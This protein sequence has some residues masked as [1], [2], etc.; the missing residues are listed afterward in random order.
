MLNHP[1]LGMSPRFSV[2]YRFGTKTA[3]PQVYAQDHLETAQKDLAAGRYVEALAHLDAAAQTN[4][5]LVS[6]VW[7]EKQ[8]RLTA[9]LA[10]TGWRKSDDYA[11]FLSAESEQEQLGRKALDAYLSGD[12]RA[13]SLWAHVALAGRP[14][15]EFFRGLLSHLSAL[16]GIPERGEDVLTRSS[17]A[18][19][20]ISRANSAF[21]YQRYDAASR[22]FEDVVL[23]EEN[24]SE[25]WVK[26][27]SCYFALGERER[28]RE[29]Y[30]RA[31]KLNAAEPTLLEFMREQGWS[32]P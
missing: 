20:K 13:A 9:L 27:G 11:R 32:T 18:Q 28:A 17:L 1:T 14:E 31:L 6:G 2:G 30:E 10:K 8:A 5:A 3:R 29:A 12:N 21:Y 25:A 19:E 16:S 24:N 22:E 23:L 26:L 15:S 7:E 4:R